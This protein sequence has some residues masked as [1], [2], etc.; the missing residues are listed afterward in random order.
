MEIIFSVLFFIPLAVTFGAPYVWDY[1]DKNT[2]YNPA[3]SI[4]IGFLFDY[5]VLYGIKQAK[6]KTEKE[7]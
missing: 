4:A 6:N 1:L 5:I 2:W 7:D 3:T